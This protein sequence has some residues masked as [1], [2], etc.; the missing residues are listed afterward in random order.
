[1]TRK[2]L[3]AAAALVLLTGAGAG[4]ALAD[5]GSWLEKVDSNGDGTLSLSELQTMSGERFDR[6]DLNDDG[7]ITQEEWQQTVA[8]HFAKMDA[9]GDGKLEAGEMK[10]G[11]RGD[12]VD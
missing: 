1:M 3:I 9:N 8:E 10:H 6:R 7:V 11:R 2:T 4:I 12:K 5:R